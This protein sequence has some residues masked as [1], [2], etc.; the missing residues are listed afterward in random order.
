MSGTAMPAAAATLE[1]MRR[2]EPMLGNRG[3]TFVAPDVVNAPMIRHWCAAIGD[4]NPVYVDPHRAA[5]SVH[6][7]IIAPPA[8][9]QVWSMPGYGVPW[10]TDPVFEARAVLDEYGFT[11]VVATNVEQNYLRPLRIGDRVRLTRVFD[12]LSPEK[13]TALGSGHFITSRYEYADERNEPVAMMMHRS[14]KFRPRMEGDKRAAADGDKR[15]PAAGD[16]APAA[17][18]QLAQLMSGD[19]R[20]IG[21]LDA[22]GNFADMSPLPPTIRGRDLAVGTRL[23]PLEIPI[24]RSF[25]V[26]AAIATRDYQEVHH[27][28]DIARAR[29]SRDIFTNILTTTG[30]VGRLLTDSLGPDAII[31]GIG[32]RLGAPNYPGDTLRLGGEVSSLSVEDNRCRADFIIRGR[33]AIGEHVSATASVELAH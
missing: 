23:A 5:Q 14:F 4:R 28:P 26:A 1:M 22:S 12:S 9:L 6:A 32:I 2:I 21:L 27:D 7:D 11:S 30:L 20:A 18:R 8:M 17:G 15:V 13:T 29:G 16:A 3:P 10:G 19:E 25:I 31:R 24:T 33:N